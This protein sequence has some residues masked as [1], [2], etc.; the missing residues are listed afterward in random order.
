[1]EAFENIK[2]AVF[3][4]AGTTVDEDNLVYKTLHMALDRIGQNV[5]FEQVLALGAGKDKRT[6]LADLIGEKAVENQNLLDKAYEFFIEDLH[7][8]YE[9]API[10]PIDGV[11]ELFE[12]L[13]LKG[14]IVVLNTGYDRPTALKILERIGW[15]EG[16]EYNALITRDDVQNGRPHADMIHLA[17]RM[18]S[19][20]DSQL[21]LKAGDSIVDILEGKN[22]LCGINIGVLSGAQTKE[23]LAQGKPHL[24]LDSVTALQQY[25]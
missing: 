24:I 6:A 13:H 19:I 18:F 3:D 2:L 23:Q 7:Q 9:K 4:M 25:F 1:M 21:V 17:M 22:A 12:L 16:R 15:K 20:T 14:V 11:L 10:R 5:T 8:A